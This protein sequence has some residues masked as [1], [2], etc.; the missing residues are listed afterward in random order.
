MKL[1]HPSSAPRI[2]TPRLYPLVVLFAAIV[3]AATVVLLFFL[4]K[5]VDF[6][7][8]HSAGGS[9]GVVVVLLTAIAGVFSLPYLLRMEVSPFMR[10]ASCAAVF[11][12]VSGWMLGLWWLEMNTDAPYVSSGLVAVYAA[13]LWAVGCVWVV[14]SPLT[15][16][17][18]HR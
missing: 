14:G 7:L 9:V 5:V 11:A 8:P 10:V 13:L 17:K 3:V 6:V 2:N 15:G 12:T 16:L 1:A 18:K 4:D